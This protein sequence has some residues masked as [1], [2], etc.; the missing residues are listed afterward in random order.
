MV[1]NRITGSSKT[2]LL[3]PTDKY[4][5]DKY[6][7]EM[8]TDSSIKN[9]SVAAIKRKSIDLNSW[10]KTKLVFDFPV[11]VEP[12]ANELPVVYVLIDNN[13]WTLVTTQ[14]IIGQIDSVMREIDF[15]YLDDTVWGSFKNTKIDKT[16]FRTVDQ[17]GEQYD[18][19]METGKPSMAI[20]SSV[21]TIKNFY[22]ENE[23]GQ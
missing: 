19:L 23:I 20:I 22:K 3:I 10:E 2:L 5:V 12:K 15:T 14:R 7:K 4:S 18:F 6:Y 8:K 16:I 21:R 11:E 13:N 17:Y 1:S 9:I